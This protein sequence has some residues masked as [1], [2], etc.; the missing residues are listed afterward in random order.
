MGKYFKKQKYCDIYIIMGKKI[1]LTEEQVMNLIGKIHL[2]EAKL[3]CR[4][5]DFNDLVE[6]LGG[7]S[8]KKIGHNT[9]VEQIDEFTIGIKYHRTYIVKMD[10]TGVLTVSTGGWETS[11]T[12][13]R[14]NQFLGC[15]N[16][17]IFQK[18][19]E[20]YIVGTNETLPYQDGMLV[21]SDGHVS[22]PVKG[23]LSY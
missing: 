5:T 20:W 1:I 15:R 10:P 12:K 21:L 18:K 14:L 13:E 16:V 6:Y 2:N 23:R 4:Y 19:G 11:T 8:S 7:K 3:A 9:F 17:R 22:A